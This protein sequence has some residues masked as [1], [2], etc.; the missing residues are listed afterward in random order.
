GHRPGEP[1]GRYLPYGLTVWLLIT[2]ILTMIVW[3]VLAG[4][5]LG[6]AIVAVLFLLLLF[7]ITT[8][9]VAE[10]GLVHSG[11]LV[12][13]YR[14]WQL[15]VGYVVSFASTLW[16]EYTYAFTKDA[17]GLLVN[18]WGAEQNPRDSIVGATIVYRRGHFDQPYSSAGHISFG[19]V[20]T[21]LLSFL[22]LRYT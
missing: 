10:A 11:R 1:Q 12:T 15:L 4:A 8:R 20:F 9:F 3:L 18:D 22:R 16:T 21:A 19:F 17:Q 13:L 7:M 6:A 5:G 2:C 14:P